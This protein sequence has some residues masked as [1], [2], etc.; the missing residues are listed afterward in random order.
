MDNSTASLQHADAH[1]SSETDLT[2]QP[3]RIFKPRHQRHLSTSSEHLSRANDK[4]GSSVS[5]RQPT[6]QKSRTHGDLSRHKASLSLDSAFEASLHVRKQRQSDP[7]HTCSGNNSDAFGK[8][9]GATLSYP[10]ARSRSRG[11]H[12]FAPSVRDLNSRFLNS[13]PTCHTDSAHR[14]SVTFPSTRPTGLLNELENRSSI[15]LAPTPSISD[16][17]RR[18]VTSAETCH[19]LAELRNLENSLNPDIGRRRS[20]KQRFIFRMM[21]SLSS[22]TRASCGAERSGERLPDLHKAAPSLLD[23]SN[24]RHLGHSRSDTISSIGTESILGGDFDTVLAAFPTPPSSNL[25]SPTTL[26]SSETSRTDWVSTVRKP[27]DVP[28]VGAELS[29]TPELSKL[30][31]DCGQSM[32]V[33]VEV[34]GLVNSPETM[35]E[36][37]LDYRRL[38]VAV[39]IDNS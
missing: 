1:G 38:D 27:E 36:A 3:L 31:S 25:T 28:V 8:L 6:M 7:V 39:V 32:Y 35:Y 5:I 30:S 9:P 19:S 34:K 23:M 26:T 12:D 14:R 33:S 22:K 11:K 15:L 29:I 24:K 2:P 4:L 13:E 18:V 21:N 37:A 10:P 20:V 17:Q 16:G